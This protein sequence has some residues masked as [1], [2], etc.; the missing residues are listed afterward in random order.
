MPGCPEVLETLGRRASLAV[1]TNKPLGRDAT[2][3]RRPRSGARTFRRTPCLGGDGPFPRKPDPA[4]LLH[5]WRAPAR[6]RV[7]R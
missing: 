7:T 6:A 1:L 5:W 4:G 2:H 3:P